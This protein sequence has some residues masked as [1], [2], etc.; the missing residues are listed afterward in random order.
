[1]TEDLEVVLEEDL[2]EDLE[3]DLEVVE[4]V[5]SSASYS[6][7][8]A[9]SGQLGTGGIFNAAFY[10]RVSIGRLATFNDEAF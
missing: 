7:T 5:P 9:S 6:E 2:E 8:V 1:M 3:V 4:A 10:Q